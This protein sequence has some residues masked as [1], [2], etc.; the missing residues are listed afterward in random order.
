MKFDAVHGIFFSPTSTS[1]KIAKGIVGGIVTENVKFTDMT[2]VLCEDVEIMPEELAVIV[3]PVYRGG[4]APTAAERL[5]AVRGNNTPAILAVVYGNRD[6][7]GALTE[8][9]G[10]AVAQGFHPVAA[11]A[12]VGEHSY[13]RPDTPVAVGRPDVKDLSAAAAFGREVAE[14][15]VSTVDHLPVLDMTHLPQ[16]KKYFPDTL[17]FVFDVLRLKIVRPE[18]PRIPDADVE[19]CTHCGACVKC[20]PVDAI[21]ADDVLH[22]DVTRC[23]RCCACVKICPAEARRFDTPFAKILAK[24][25]ARRKEPIWTTL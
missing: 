22:S 23:I 24:R 19:K 3:V 7:E 15:L 13:S 18:M 25:A 12:F 2:H 4:V 10:L 16:V 11:A 5:R 17:G 14:K 1:N 9:N 6:F 8:L 20:C 21:P